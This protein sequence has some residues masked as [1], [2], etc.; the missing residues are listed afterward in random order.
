MCN[1]P[2]WVNERGVS[3]P[4]LKHNSLSSVTDLFPVAMLPGLNLQNSHPV[5]LK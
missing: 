4:M 5:M 1:I 3:C 2:E